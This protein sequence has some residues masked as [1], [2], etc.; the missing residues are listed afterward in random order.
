MCFADPAQI[1]S[2]DGDIAT[3]RHADGSSRVSVLPLRALPR[4]VQP[5]DWVLV[6]LGLAID[7]I[8]EDEGR[9]LLDQLRDL[10]RAVGSAKS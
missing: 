7:A 9:F 2:I 5:G 1:D 10:R 4:P 3:V 6:S 8:S